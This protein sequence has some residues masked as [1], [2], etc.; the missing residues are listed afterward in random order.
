MVRRKFRH[1]VSLMLVRI[2]RWY[3]SWL[4]PAIWTTVKMHLWWRQI[5]R[6]KRSQY[7]QPV[8][9]LIIPQTTLARAPPLSLVA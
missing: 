3:N 9:N 2:R 8:H 7:R 5:V 1:R 6:Q 4:R